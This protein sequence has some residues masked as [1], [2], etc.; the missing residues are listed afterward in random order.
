MN[1][2]ASAQIEVPGS[3]RLNHNRPISDQYI[4]YKSPEAQAI[5]KWFEDLSYYEKTLEEMSQVSQEDGFMD[6]L[7]AVENWFRVLSEAERTACLYNLIKE[8]TPIQIRFFTTVLQ[9]MAA[10]D[11][12][13]DRLSINLPKA[14]ISKPADLR[15][16]S[17]LSNRSS[18]SRLS[19][20]L[21]AR[22]RSML[23]SQE[24]FESRNSSNLSFSSSS[25]KLASVD[26]WDTQ[27]KQRTSSLQLSNEFSKPAM[28][29]P[30]SPNVILDKFISKDKDIA[31]PSEVQSLPEP[32]PANNNDESLND[33]DKNKPLEQIDTQLIKGI[34]C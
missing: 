32:M 21:G 22:V 19:Q 26:D 6:E 5:D 28:V 25:L 2:P 27:L 31:K 7:K 8:S 3:Y 16:S 14:S 13:L 20:D 34:E 12:S 33:V 1:R 10:K 17:V 29:S 11:N 30:V 9:Q 4:P 18:A 15:I 24:D 23:G